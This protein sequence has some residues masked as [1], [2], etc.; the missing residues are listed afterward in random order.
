M[1]SRMSDPVKSIYEKFNVY[2]SAVASLKGRQQ[3]FEGEEEEVVKAA[4]KVLLE[5]H[6]KKVRTLWMDLEELNFK[7]MKEFE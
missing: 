4:R 7:L 2:L 1:M 3:E 6:K 5:V